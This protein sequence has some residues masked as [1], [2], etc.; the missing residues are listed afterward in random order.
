MRVASLDTPERVPQAVIIRLVDQISGEITPFRLARSCRPRSGRY[1]PRALRLLGHLV[2]LRSCRPS[3]SLLLVPAPVRFRE[4]G[5]IEFRI[6]A[7]EIEIPNQRS[8]ERQFLRQL[9]R[10]FGTA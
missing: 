6:S 10:G 7:A 1:K 2:R 8:Q 9:D 4:N 5:K 3:P